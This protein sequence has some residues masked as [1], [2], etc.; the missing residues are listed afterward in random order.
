SSPTSARSPWRSTSICPG[1]GSSRRMTPDRSAAMTDDDAKLFKE[2]VGEVAP[3]RA[4]DTVDQ[5]APREITPGMR[6][7]RRAAELAIARARSFAAA[8]GRAAAVKPGDEAS[9]T[10][11]G[12]QHGVFKRRRQGKYALDARLALHRMPVDRARHAL[13]GFVTDCVDH[14][15]RCALIT[16]G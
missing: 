10:R 16:H 7:R 11:D 5:G 9:F 15:I 8:V 3:L 2:F 13:L 6:A 4:A 12:G 1:S 14:R